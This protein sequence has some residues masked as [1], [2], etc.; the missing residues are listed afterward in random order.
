VEGGPVLHYIIVLYNKNN[1]KMTACFEENW[2]FIRN[3]SFYKLD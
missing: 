3:V 1:R 2:I